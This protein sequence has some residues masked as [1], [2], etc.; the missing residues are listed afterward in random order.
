MQIQ[1]HRG[2]V[3]QQNSSVLGDRHCQ[4]R[5]LALTK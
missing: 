2:L 4:H 5:K 3:Q 1:V